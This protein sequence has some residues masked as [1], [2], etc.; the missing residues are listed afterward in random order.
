MTQ[1]SPIEVAAI[2]AIHDQPMLDQVQRWA[3]INSGTRNLTGLKT[4]ATALGDAFS[5]L[6]A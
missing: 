2:E 3:A 1:L 6:P 5:A 4:V